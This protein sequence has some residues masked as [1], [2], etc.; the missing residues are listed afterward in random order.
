MADNIDASCVNRACETRT[1]TMRIVTLQ[2]RQ[3]HDTSLYGTAAL[4]A[5]LTALTVVPMQ[6]AAAQGAVPCTAIAD[7][8]ERLAC[9]DRALRAPPSTATP[10]ATTPPAQAAPR[11]APPAAAPAPAAQSAAEP[12]RRVRESTARPAPA[13]PRAP[14]AATNDGADGESI[15]IVIVGT[16]ALPG[17]ETTFTAQDGTSW[18][19]TDSQRI[20]GLPDPPFDAEIKP[21][22]M[23]SYFLVAKDRQRAIRVRPVR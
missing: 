14:A 9:Y 17:R 8:A 19:Q 23:G 7:D 6:S 11:S 12:P 15:P 20:T 4:A 16:R 10:A 1:T 2:K 3:D 21:G 22:A 18:I 13:T 5:L